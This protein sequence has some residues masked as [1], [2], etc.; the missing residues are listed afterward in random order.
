[1]NA[2]GTWTQ[3]GI[4]KSGHPHQVGKRKVLAPIILSVKE[5]PDLNVKGWL[6]KTG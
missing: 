3:K 4:E 6:V 1:M 2:T 5:S